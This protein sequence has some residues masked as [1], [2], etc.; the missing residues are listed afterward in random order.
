MIATKL[1]EV[2]RK[3]E[4]ELHCIDVAIHQESPLLELQGHGKITTISTGAIHLEFVCTKINKP[5]PRTIIQKLPADPFDN[6]Q[7]LKLTATTTN[8]WTFTSTEFSL[9]MNSFISSAPFVTGLLLKFIEFNYQETCD[10]PHPKG[11]NFEILEPC[12][13]P[14][15]R[16]NTIKGTLRGYES[17]N[18]NQTLLN[19]DTPS[20]EL[21]IVEHEDYMEIDAQ[22]DFNVDEMQESLTYYLALTSGR[23][24]QP[25]AVLRR[26]GDNL[27]LQLRSTN[28]D[29]RLHKVAEPFPRL[30]SG[31]GWPKSHYDIF[32]GML[33]VRRI[34]P[35][36]FQSAYAQWTRVW[37]AHRSQNSVTLL[38]LGV[39]IEGLLN[40]IFIPALNKSESDD[41][42]EKIK[43]EVIQKLNDLEIQDS[44]RTTLTD[45]VKKWG[46]IHPKK[47][48]EM[49]IKRG[50]IDSAQRKSWIDMRN[51]S[52]HPKAVGANSEVSHKDF[53]RM[54]DC[55]TLF[56]I[57]TLN[58]FGYKGPVY[59]FG[60]LGNPDLIQRDFVSIVDSADTEG[61]NTTESDS[62]ST[63]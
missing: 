41:T 25:F 45:S 7:Q 56:Y 44:H 21:S 8:G 32:T 61:D 52:A 33:R 50:L 12:R 40:D 31:P 23:L 48:L 57:L 36:I 3:G 49:L 22:G 20:C 43:L 28:K 30:I 62:A 38:T 1:F 58:I 54:C 6:K 37:H 55:L 27:V 4:L 15:N 60:K 24:P 39:A 26:S 46:N 17:H 5:T 35:K 53:T 9:K 16:V 11:L 10:Y 63:T 14:T 42:F 51:S 59:E 2:M 18:W 19:L 13:I 29:Y 47:A 34:S